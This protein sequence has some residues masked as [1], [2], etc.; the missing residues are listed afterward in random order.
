MHKIFKYKIENN[1]TRIPI[2]AKVLR[3]DHVDDGFYKGDFLWAIVDVDQK[4]MVDFEW[5]GKPYSA[6]RLPDPYYMGQ[7]ELKVKE[8]QS[9]SIYGYPCSAGEQDGKIYVYSDHETARS[10]LDTYDIAVFKTG[11]AIDIPIEKLR[12]LGLNRLWIIQELGL[13]TFEVLS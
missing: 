9:I 11:Q 5:S 7:H 1:H 13:Y 2:G 6:A 8:K 12:Y 3:I 10:K 4:E